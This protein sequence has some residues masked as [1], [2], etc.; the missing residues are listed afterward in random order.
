MTEPETDEL[1]MLFAEARE[2]RPDVSAALTA[3]IVADAAAEM[4]RRTGRAE[5]APSL[6]RAL[7]GWVGAG[8]LGAATLAGVWIGLAA[9][10]A[11]S[12]VTGGLLGEP[13]VVSLLPESDLLLDAE[14]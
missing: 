9:P 3:R 14:G 2:T 7:G 6:W 8:T 5:A 11:L 4:P 1:D 12:G 13:V 10:S